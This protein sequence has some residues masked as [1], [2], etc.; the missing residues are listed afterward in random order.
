LSLRRVDEASRKRNVQYE[1][2]EEKQKK[3]RLKEDHYINLYRAVYGS[4]AGLY[5]STI[6]KMPEGELED[7]IKILAHIADKM[8]SCL[9]SWTDDELRQQLRDNVFER[10]PTPAEIE[11]FKEHLA[12]DVGQWLSDNLKSFFMKLRD[13]GKL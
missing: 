4:N 10:E 11:A 3:R 13:E 6:S 5:T 2:E 7:L 8:K 9:V 1:V 12:K